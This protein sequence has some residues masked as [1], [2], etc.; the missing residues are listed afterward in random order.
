MLKA[1]AAI[2]FC[3]VTLP[4]VCQSKNKFQVGT[5]T[6]VERSRDGENPSSDRGAYDISIQV[7]HTVYV[8]R[9][10]AEFGLNTVEYAA[11]RDL[12]RIT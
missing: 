4:A 2:L 11:G 3:L 9:Y 7:D 5:I 6:A 1:T 10:K 12:V 8:V